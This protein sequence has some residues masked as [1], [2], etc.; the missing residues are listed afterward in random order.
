MRDI[1]DLFTALS[2]SRFRQRFKLGI[3]EQ[4]YFQAKGLAIIMEHGEDFIR[5]RLAPA[6]PKNDG[7]QTP[8]KNHPVFI[9]QHATAT[10]CR[11]CLANWHGIERGKTLSEKEIA[12]ILQVISYWIE[13]YSLA[14]NP[15]GL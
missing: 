2:R 14:S 11:K 13:R 4:A 3:K 8:M 9:A 12:Y 10:C 15:G 1:E 5:E 7:K 6:A